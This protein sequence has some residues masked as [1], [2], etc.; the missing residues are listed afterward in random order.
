VPDSFSVTAEHTD[1]LQSQAQRLPQAEVL[2]AIDLLA[3]ALSAVKDGSDPRIQLEIA[4]LKSAQPKAD[5]SVQAL[6]ARI[7]RLEQ[8][9]G[10]RP[11]APAAQEAPEPQAEPA[12]SAPEP[13]EE[14]A[15]P[16]PPRAAAVG[17]SAPVVEADPEPE[18]DSEPEPEPEPQPEPVGA[19][20]VDLEHVRSLW[21]AA[22]EAVREENA[23]VG[24]LLADARPVE[25][26]DRRLTISFAAG[27]T[28]SKKKAENNRALLAKAM[29]DLT[30][31]SLELVYE[32]RDGEGGGE[33]EPDASSSLD[34]EQLLER[35]KQEFGATEVFDTEE[36]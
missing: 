11:P 3:A 32:L 24:A 2:R 33:G 6:M 4:L 7:E 20:P 28:F 8:V 31:H 18:P 25:L 29:R 27:A 26:Q 35:L 17:G 9:L 22:V 14:V 5:A 13:A 36:S 21:P 34:E 1:R 10:G 30:G 23:M 15:A 16:E 19:L 12:P